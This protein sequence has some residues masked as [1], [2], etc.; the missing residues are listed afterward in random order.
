[1][2]CVVQYFWDHN[3]HKLDS[4]IIRFTLCQM[5]RMKEKLVETCV[6]FTVVVPEN[7]HTNRGKE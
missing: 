5:Q 1:M 2:S 6:I 4:N 3:K 7:S